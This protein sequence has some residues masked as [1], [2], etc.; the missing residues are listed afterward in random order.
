MAQGV[1]GYLVWDLLR[2]ACNGRLK[3]IKQEGGSSVQRWYKKKQPNQ[4]KKKKQTR[5]V[6][7]MEKKARPFFCG[8]VWL[9]AGVRFLNLF[10]LFWRWWRGCGGISFCL[11]YFVSIFL[12]SSVDHT[13]VA[14]TLRC[15]V[16]A[17]VSVVVCITR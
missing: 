5:R 3:K 2:N 9:F 12:L 10:L 17:V 15:G 14:S 6:V 8:L 16:H 1:Q 4:E 13:V 11:S 7:M